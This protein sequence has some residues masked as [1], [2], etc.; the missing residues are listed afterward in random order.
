MRAS[1]S[2]S[3][4]KRSITQNYTER[5]HS[6]NLEVIFSGRPLEWRA[7]GSSEPWRTSKI[8]DNYDCRK[9]GPE[10]NDPRGGRNWQ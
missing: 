2:N 6:A 8:G 10:G 5:A 9:A 7:I 1:P 3:A 4:E